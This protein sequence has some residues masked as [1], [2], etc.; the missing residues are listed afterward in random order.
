MHLFAI[1]E[2]STLR[3]DCDLLR[4]V[5]LYLTNLFDRVHGLFDAIE[6][7]TVE[8]LVETET[9]RSSS[10][11]TLPRSCCLLSVGQAEI[12]SAAEIA[13]MATASISSRMYSIVPNRES[14][15]FDGT[16]ST[17]FSS[18]LSCWVGTLVWFRVCLFDVVSPDKF[19]CT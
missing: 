4:Q 19:P 11:L 16:Q 8:E 5:S 10:A 2:N 3:R 17:L 7:F 15:A 13:E 9:A 6:Q 14:Y 18:K 12:L 1:L